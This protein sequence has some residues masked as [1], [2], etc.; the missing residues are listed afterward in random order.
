MTTNS[1]PS[2]AL[3]AFRSAVSRVVLGADRPVRLLCAALLSGGH[4]LIEDRPGTGK[5]TLAKAAARALS[6]SFKRIQFT[7][8]LLPGDVTGGLVYLP[9]R[10]AMEFRPGPIFADLVLADELNRATPRTQS[11]LLEAMAER[12]VTADGRTIP[13][14]EHFTVLATVNPVESHGVQALP[15]AELDRFLCSFSLG[16]PSVEDEARLIENRREG[17]PLDD[18]EPAMGPDDLRAL[19]AA[20]RAIPVDRELTLYVAELLKAIR[21]HDDVRLGASP[22]AGLGL[23]RFAQALALMDGLDH[24]RPEQLQEAAVP[25]L[26][27]RVFLRDGGAG[28]EETAFWITRLLRQVPLPR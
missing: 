8:D 20:A 24:V 28:T 5:T 19:K 14:G 1:T 23:Y 17:D 26:R 2:Q 22:R 11:A 9:D 4:A 6:V 10:G 25:V 15:E 18:V 7:P 27:H 16:Y 12:Q 21:A 13:L 3:D